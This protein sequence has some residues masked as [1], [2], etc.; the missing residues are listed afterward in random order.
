[1][2]F[3]RGSPKSGLHVLV[4]FHDVVFT[5]DLVHK[6]TANGVTVYPVEDFSFQ[7]HGRHVNEI[8]L[9][10]AHLSFSEIAKGVEKIG[11]VI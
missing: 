6:I 8:I 11:E 2:L 10:Y 4:S 7:N 1:L 5:E 9:G 3:E